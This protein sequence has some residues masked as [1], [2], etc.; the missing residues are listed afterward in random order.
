MFALTLLLGLAFAAF[1]SPTRKC[2][3]SFMPANICLVLY[4]CASLWPSGR[5]LALIQK[6]MFDV[7]QLFS[8]SW[9]AHVRQLSHEPSLHSGGVFGKIMGSSSDGSGRVG[10][11]T[12]RRIRANCLFMAFTMG[13]VISATGD[14][15]MDSL[16]ILIRRWMRKTNFSRICSASAFSHSI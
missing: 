16:F 8:V 4:S 7:Y 1:L 11:T 9:N 6:R 15:V 5:L 14:A 10:L 12:C 13:L 2:A 3:S